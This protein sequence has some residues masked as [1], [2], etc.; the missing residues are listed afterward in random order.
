MPLADLPDPTGRPTSGT[1]AARALLAAALLLGLTRF[2]KLGAWGLWVDEAHSLNDSLAYFTR[3]P[4][5]YPLGYL[6]TA[7]VVALS[8]GAID[9][10]SLRLF[11][12]ICGWLSI[13]MCAWALRPAIGPTRAAATALLVSASSWHLYWSQ[14][15]R[16]YTLALLIA[17]AAG[18]LWLRGLFEARRGLLL[19]GLLG[20]SVS[21]FAHPT[22]AIFVPVWILASLLARW[23]GIR[24]PRRPPSAL[25]LG[26]SLVGLVAMGGWALEVWRTYEGVKAGASL[27]HFA[28][29]TGWY[30][31]P[32]YLIGCSV[33]VWL[34]WR[35][36][37]PGDVLVA[38]VVLLFGATAILASAIVK[39]AAQYVFVLLPWVAA[40]ATGPLDHLRRASL[41]WAWLALLLLPALSDSVLYFALRHGDRPRWREAYAYVWEQRGPDDLVLGM[42]APIGEYYLRPGKEWLRSQAALLRL[43]AFGFEAGVIERGLR[44]GRRVWIVLN[45]EDL[46]A[47]STAARARFQTILD[48]QAHLERVWRVP[49]TPRDM[50]VRVYSL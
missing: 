41:R 35:R 3:T 45:P 11:P 28:L 15:A 6:A 13:P 23:L 7:L 19:A 49:W 9:E 32:L 31:T 43:D 50:D 2:L 16:A 17:T 12:A 10:A 21:A 27:L 5:D 22:G 42:H 33:G 37:E 48:G 39:I 46:M 4:Q 1:R 20:G 25:L 24:L 38:L 34:A 14:S 26:A 36:R 40:L 18:G 47:W 29:T 30:M 8:G 44:Q